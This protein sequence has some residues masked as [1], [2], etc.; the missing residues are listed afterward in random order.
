MI[1]LLCIFLY[2]PYIVTSQSGFLILLVSLIN[3]KPELVIKDSYPKIH[4]NG[5]LV[6][7]L[8][9][10]IRGSIEELLAVANDLKHSERPVI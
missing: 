8:F 5:S 6:S 2:S 9:R 4:K 3:Q 1:P 7:S 10:Y